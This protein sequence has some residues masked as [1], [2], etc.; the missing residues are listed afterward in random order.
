[1]KDLWYETKVARTIREGEKIDQN[2]EF[3]LGPAFRVIEGISIHGIVYA[4]VF[5]LSKNR[6]ETNCLSKTW[7]SSYF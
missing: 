2:L 3:Y 5:T 1:M 6:P 7:S 4:D